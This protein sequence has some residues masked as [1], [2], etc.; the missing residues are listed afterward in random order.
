M[1][2]IYTYRLYLF[3]ELD[4]REVVEFVCTEWLNPKCAALQSLRYGQWTCR[5][6]R[7]EHYTFRVVVS[8]LFH[9]MLFLQRV[10]L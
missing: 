10:V 4:G 8:S 9:S 7:I 2:N 6:V 5:S 3:T 1:M